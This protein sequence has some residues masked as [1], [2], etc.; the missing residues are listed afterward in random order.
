MAE[1]NIDQILSDVL[2]GKIKTDCCP[3]VNEMVK[4]FQ[5]GEVSIEDLRNILIQKQAELMR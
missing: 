4:K 1:M 2:D 5:N 3:E